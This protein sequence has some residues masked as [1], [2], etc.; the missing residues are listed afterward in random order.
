MRLHCSWL[1]PISWTVK[2]CRYREMTRRHDC[3]PLHST[4]LSG[5]V[6]KRAISNITAGHFTVREENEMIWSRDFLHCLGVCLVSTAHNIR[7]S[8]CETWCA[9]VVNFSVCQGGPMLT[10]YIKRNYFPRFFQTCLSAW[11]VPYFHVCLSV[12]FSHASDVGSR[13]ANASQSINQ[14]FWSRLNYKCISTTIGWIAM[15]FGARHSCSPE[16]DL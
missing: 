1:I 6:P 16:D 7:K 10:V 15:E 14:P 8:Q 13:D 3:N 12:F 4:F 9:S 5:V 2:Q 11:I